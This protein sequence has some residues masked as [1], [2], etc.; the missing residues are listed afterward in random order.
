MLNGEYAEVLGWQNRDAAEFEEKEVCE[1][2]ANVIL[3]NYKQYKKRVAKGHRLNLEKL[4]AR[5]KN[6]KL[7]K[8]FRAFFSKIT[9][10]KKEKSK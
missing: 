2:V 1:F 4:N 3:Y 6:N 9:F 10:R 7:K 8:N 5:F